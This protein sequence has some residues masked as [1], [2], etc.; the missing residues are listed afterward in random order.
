MSACGIDS[1]LGQFLDVVALLFVHVFPLDRSNSGVKFV[2]MGGWLLS[3]TEG[4][5]LTSGYGLDRFSLP[6]VGYFS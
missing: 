5:C 3:S 6:F 2:K 1:Q 4:S